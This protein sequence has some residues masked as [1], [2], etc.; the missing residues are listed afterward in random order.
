MTNPT[1]QEIIDT[2]DDLARLAG[3]AIRLAI[4]SEGR[5]SQKL[6]VIDDLHKAIF[7]ALPPKPQP[8]MAEVEWDDDKHYLAEAEHEYQGAVTMLAKNTY[9]W[10]LC[11][12]RGGHEVFTADPRLLTLISRRYT[13]TEVQE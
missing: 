2:Y 7:K 10:V 12:R 11:F 5:N 3:I 8:T 4:K 6:D 9:G 13:L 1:R